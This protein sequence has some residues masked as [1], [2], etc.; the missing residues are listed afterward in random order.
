MDFKTFL[1][2]FTAVFLAELADKTQLVG[3]SLAAET[4][5]PVSVLAGSVSGYFVVTLLTV[6]VGS[7]AGKYINPEVIR[8]VGASL[9][10][11]LGVLMMLGKV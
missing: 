8:Y 5:K 3:L 10:I 7:I 2:T 6:I 11:L 9:F 1:T 4:K